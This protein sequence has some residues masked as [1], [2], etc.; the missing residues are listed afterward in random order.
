MAFGDF[1]IR[2][3]LNPNLGY[4]LRKLENDKKFLGQYFEGSGHSFCKIRNWYKVLTLRPSIKHLCIEK[5]LMETIGRSKRLIF[6]Q[7]V[8][9][10][11]RRPP[12]SSLINTTL[13]TL[14]YILNLI[15]FFA[16][17]LLVL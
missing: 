13:L 16:G 17:K 3:K 5:V 6:K 14:L 8:N 11:I 10:Y 7:N 9:K 12:K 2:L 1:L 4:E 15:L